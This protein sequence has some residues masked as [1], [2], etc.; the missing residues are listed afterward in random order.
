MTLVVTSVE[1]L[2]ETTRSFLSGTVMPQK[3]KVKGHHHLHFL[4]EFHTRCPDTVESQ[5]LT[6]IFNSEINFSYRK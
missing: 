4:K 1:F 2:I 5:I 3:I 6:R